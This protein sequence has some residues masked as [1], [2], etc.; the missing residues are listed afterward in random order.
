MSFIST[1]NFGE[2][3]KKEGNEKTQTH[4]PLVDLGSSLYAPIAPH[5]ATLP[6][7]FMFCKTQKD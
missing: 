6:Y 4:V 5:K 3:I 7:S 1:K 2:S